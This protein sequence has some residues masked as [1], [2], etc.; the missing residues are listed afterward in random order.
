MAGTTVYVDINEVSHD[1]V[2]TFRS[3]LNLMV[4]D[5]EVL[6]AALSL[7]DTVLDQQVKP[8]GVVSGNYTFAATAAVTV[9]VAGNVKYRINGIEHFVE[10]PTTLTLEDLGDVTQNNFGAWR[11]EIDRLGAITAKAS[12]TVGGYSTA[13][14]ALLAMGGLAPTANCCT[15]GYVTITKTGSAFNIGTDNTNV[16]TSA[17]VAYYEKAPRK[18]V[19]GLTSARGSVSAYVAASTTINSGTVDAQMNGLR[20]AQIAAAAT[21]ALTDAD[22]ITTLKYGAVLLMTNLAGTGIVSLNAAGTP[23]VTAMA[24]NTAALARAAV[25]LVVDRLPA[26][27]VPICL[28][29][30]YNGAGGTF[31]F[32]TTNWDATSVV[33]TVTDA[34]VAGWARGTATGF[35]S[36]QL[37]ATQPSTTVVST[38]STMTAPLVSTFTPVRGS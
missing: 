37:T 36:H 23:G 9:L 6:R 10:L 16:A 34:G 2:S 24:Y 15:L 29:E 5:L 13:Q 35:N 33:T 4:A 3:T 12:P 38:A 21:Q 31:T 19:S 32:K 28:V 17:L 8:D 26:M 1:P 25:D 20:K 22:T 30:V 14:I 18:R 7:V 11:V 27:F